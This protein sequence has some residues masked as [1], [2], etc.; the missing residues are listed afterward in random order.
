MFVCC[1]GV[2]AKQF[3]VLLKVMKQQQQEQKP[4]LQ[5]VPLPIEDLANIM[6]Q[7]VICKLYIR[8]RSV[9]VAGLLWVHVV[10]DIRVF[11]L[12]RAG[13]GQIC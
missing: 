12:C 5:P 4:K 6:P 10:P 1:V 13:L 8:S 3:D 11:A 2:S 7:E 9:R